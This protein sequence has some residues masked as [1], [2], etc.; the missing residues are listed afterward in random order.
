MATKPTKPTKRNEPTNR[1]GHGNTRKHTEGVEMK[2]RHEALARYLVGAQDGCAAH[3]ILSVFFR[4]L[5]CVS[6]ANAGFGMTQFS[7]V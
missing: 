4:V 1:I 7:W 5:P 3:M 6:V 2:Q